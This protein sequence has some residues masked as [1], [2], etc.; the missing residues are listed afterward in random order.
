MKITWGN[1]EV[2][3]TFFHNLLYLQKYN[4]MRMTLYHWQSC[5]LQFC[6][7]T[8]AIILQ[9]F[10]QIKKRDYQVGAVCSL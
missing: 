1:K 7:I 4:L 3:Q 5:I 9:K 8:K 10:L 6:N 2:P